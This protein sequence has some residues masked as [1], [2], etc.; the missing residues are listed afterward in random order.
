MILDQNEQFFTPEELSRRL[1]LSAAT[2]YKLIGDNVIPAIQLGKSYRIPASEL[3]RYLKG[4]LKRGRIPAVAAAF[5][6]LLKSSPLKVKV[7]GVTLFGS[8][9]RG[10]AGKHSDVDLLLV[11]K[12]LNPEINQTVSHLATEAMEKGDF[13]EE[14]S[15]LRRTEE[16]WARMRGTTLHRAIERDGIVL[17]E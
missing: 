2:I 8:Q 4:Q 5:V 12:S 13:T 7:A 3:D 11:L 1:K 9:A 17:W 15:I 6:E 16:Q 10:G 14:L